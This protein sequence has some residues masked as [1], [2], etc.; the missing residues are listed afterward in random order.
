METNEAYKRIRLLRV[1]SSL[2]GAMKKKFTAAERA[3]I[4]QEEARILSKIADLPPDHRLVAGICARGRRRQ[5]AKKAGV[6]EV[7]LFFLVKGKVFAD[8]IP[9]TKAS[10]HAELRVYDVDHDKYWGLL[11][12]IGAAPRDL[13]YDQVP[14][15]RVV[16]D[17]KPQVH[18]ICRQVHHQEQEAPR[19]GHGATRP[20]EQQHARSNR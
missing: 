11:Q 4:R 19:A 12:R 7:G 13:D 8:G 2:R 20:V 14:R 15:G 6:P 16:Y 9:W 3:Q 1:W 5:D 10:G 18:S 17:E